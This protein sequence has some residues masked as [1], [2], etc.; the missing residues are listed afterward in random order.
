[1]ALIT[2]SGVSWDDFV[3]GLEGYRDQFTREGSER[4]YAG[5]LDAIEGT[6]QA[7]LP[8]RAAD[9]VA[10][11]NKWACRLSTARAPGGLEVWLQGHLSALADVETLTITDPRVP[12]HTEDLGGLHD[13]LIREMRAAAV[14]N[15]ADAAASK[16]LHLLNPRLFVMW[17][18]EIRRSAPEGYGAYLLQMHELALRLAEQ[19]PAEDLEA[20]LQ[21]RLGYET[22]KTLAKYLDE[23]N[24]FEAVGRE[25][26]TARK[27]RSRAAPG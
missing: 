1:M 13:D 9:I 25:Q 19:A 21:E 10:L 27:A 17:D 20:S 16:A 2:W 7:A 18:K 3:T 8:G 15:M 23:Y 26:L 14:L 12:E 5:L 11:L 22:R 6:S 4:A 24:W